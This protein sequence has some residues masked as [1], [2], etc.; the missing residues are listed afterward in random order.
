MI[1]KKSL[2]PVIIGNSTAAIAAAEAIHQYAPEISPILVAEEN[3]LPYSPTSLIAYSE[4]RI[5]DKEIFFR[6]AGVYQRNHIEVNLGRRVVRVDPQKR[7][8]TLEGGK[9]IAFSTLLIATGARPNLPLNSV[10]AT[11][12]ALTLRNL[13]DARLLHQKLKTSKEACIVGAGLIGMEFAQALLARGI[14]TNIVELQ[15]QIIPSSFD[16][17]AASMIQRSFEEQGVRFFLNANDLSFKSRKRS[18]VKQVCINGGV[19]FNTD[20]I[21]WTTGVSP[22]I[23]LVEGT[24]IQIKRGICVDKR[25]ETSAPGIFAAGDV[26]EGLDFFSGRQ[27]LNPILPAAAAQG[28][29]AGMN[30]IGQQIEFPG[31]LKM[32]I[33]P[34]FGKRAFSVGESAP[35]SEDEEIVIRHTPDEYGK[36]LLRSGKLVGGQFVKMDLEPG[37]FREMVMSREDFSPFRQRFIEDIKI[38]PRIWMMRR[39]TEGVIPRASG[40]KVG[41]RILRK[42]EGELPG[43][44]PHPIDCK[45]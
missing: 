30:M 8:V 29:V 39:R 32:N 37:I 6:D 31:N 23:D 11:G 16:A 5:G 20:L 19:A 42:D 45:P 35:T 25:M 34:Y 41:K 9:H 7:R 14:S 38:F 21:I 36:I 1:S 27:I 12:E 4:G 40:S 10:L 18:K 28:K 26:A 3:H 24:S 13:R 15:P 22:R 2:R 33:F 44:F 17:A 43:I